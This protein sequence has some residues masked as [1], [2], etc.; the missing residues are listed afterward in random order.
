[1]KHLLIENR[2]ELDISS[3]VL[4]GASTKRNDSGKIGFFGSGNKYAI[5][6]L[7]RHGIKFYVFSGDKK[8]DIATEDVSFRDMTFKRI[9]I[10]GQ[11]TSLTTDMGPLWE[12]WM[13]IREWVSN[14]IDEG[15]YSVVA[16]T[17]NVSGREGY[18]RFYVEH[19]PSIN[20]MIENWN[21]YFTFDREDV[22]TQGVDGKVFPQ[23]DEN[24]NLVLYRKGIRVFFDK[25]ITSLYQYDLSTYEINES[26]LIDSIHTAEYRTC[27]FLANTSN[28]SVARQ[29][30]AKAFIDNHWEG[31]LPWRYGCGGSLG[32][33]WRTA[34][35]NHVIIV[36][37]VS[38][39]FM[40]IQQ[41]K[42]CY[43][44]SVEMAQQIK[45]S[46]SDVKVY[47]M[48]D[49]G[50]TVGFKQVDAN[51]KQQFLL[52]DCL[53]F[54]EETQ[55]SVDYPIEIVEFE[56]N[57]VLGRAFQGKILLASRLFEQGKKEI[58]RT[59]IEENE[60]LKTGF[61]DCSRAFQNHLFNLF[62]TEKEE[63]FGYFL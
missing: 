7:I 28:I 39:Y 32:S 52:K 14:S 44:V 33:A 53:K 45:R 35:D 15:A 18:T 42:P 58:V 55:Y 3:L 36:D 34:I 62:L 21:S 51:T 20:E 24:N 25:G 61:K 5:A 1:M 8:I 6:T 54:C 22:V 59:L 46:F 60:H 26:R 48:D 50:E 49:S 30:L 4:L 10:D 11:A 27:R 37:N 19:D 57:A 40:D 41:S 31:R 16:S 2:G 9:Y 63:R 12:P 56:D 47:G 13:A 17:D 43:I 23:T 38:G 29:I